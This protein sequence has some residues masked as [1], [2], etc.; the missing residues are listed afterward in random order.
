ML[1]TRL[2]FTH[3]QWLL[4][5]TITVSRRLT[6]HLGNELSEKPLYTGFLSPSLGYFTWERYLRPTIRN[7]YF[8]D[9]HLNFVLRSSFF[10]LLSS[11]VFA[12]TKYCLNK[13]VRTV[14]ECGCECECGCRRTEMDVN[15]EWFVP[16][17]YVIPGGLFWSWPEYGKLCIFIDFAKNGLYSESVRR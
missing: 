5:H 2:S 4:F 1:T 13:L 15:D 16:Y 6:Y 10:F 7:F 11:F 17:S 14:S 12:D 3:D 9:R 8:L